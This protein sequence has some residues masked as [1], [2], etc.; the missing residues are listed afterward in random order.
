MKSPQ[1]TYTHSDG[2]L[3]EGAKWQ[4]EN[5]TN[6]LSD[7]P[8]EDYKKQLEQQKETGN[9]ENNS[10][11]KCCKYPLC[12]VM[13]K[14]SEIISQEGIFASDINIKIAMA[15]ACEYYKRDD[16]K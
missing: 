3:D 15:N 12:R 7:I 1:K 4:E 11:Y 9:Y 13:S 5:E 8:P 16:T 14:I 6:F 10:C 2:V